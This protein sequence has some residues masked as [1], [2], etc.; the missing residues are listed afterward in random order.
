M[1]QTRAVSLFCRLAANRKTSLPIRPS[2]MLLLSYICSSNIHVT[3]V[4][5]AANFYVTKAN[6]TALAKLLVK[7]GYIEK[8]PSDTDRRSYY[9][10]PTPKAYELIKEHEHDPESI[11][12]FLKSKMG[13]D[14][15]ALVGLLD[16]AN[17]I[18]IADMKAK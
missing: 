18:L 7:D 1:T 9:L 5:A 13:K 11:E 10:T 12:Q 16:T 15:D 8:V 6:I 4:M 2:E 3:P 17:A 14:F